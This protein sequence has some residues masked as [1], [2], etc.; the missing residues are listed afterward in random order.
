LRAASGSLLFA[1][2]FSG[3]AGA[4]RVA[5]FMTRLESA[6]FKV[7]LQAAYILGVLRDRRAVPVLSKALS[8]P[9]YAVRAAAAGALGNIGDGAAAN[10]LGGAIG[11]EE[12]WVRAEVVRSL[13]KLKVRETLPKIVGALQDPDSKVRLFA[14][15]ALGEIGDGTAVQALAGVIESG[16]GE[17][18]LEEARRMLARLSATIDVAETIGRLK[19]GDDKHVRARAAV[20]LGVLNDARVVPSLIEAL[21]DSESY[22]RGQCAL[23]LANTADPRALTALK[24][25][26]E[27]ESDA[28]VRSIAHLSLSMLRRKLGT[29]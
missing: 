27:R 7:R 20:L 5:H 1:L 17:E 23:A 10:A 9:H 29:P 2:A 28:R 3:T 24:Q 6:G 26:I 18:L 16:E 14:V 15:R 4:D 21:S 19:S 12:P 8:D 22:V 25:L 13:G 11:D